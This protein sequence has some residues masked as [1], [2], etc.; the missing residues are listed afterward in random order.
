MAKYHT[1]ILLPIFFFTLSNFI[2]MKINKGSLKS[3]I[4][5]YV[6]PAKLEELRLKLGAGVDSFNDMMRSPIGSE[7]KIWHYRLAEF[8]SQT[9]NMLVTAK[10]ILCAEV[11]IIYD[12]MNETFAIKRNNPETQAA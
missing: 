8:I 6:P 1:E 10:E 11:V 12:T 5:S 4:I 2:L 7:P 9:T 3:L